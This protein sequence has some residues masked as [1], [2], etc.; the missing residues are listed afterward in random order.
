MKVASENFREWPDCRN[1]AIVNLAQAIK[2]TTTW[3][4]QI[5]PIMRL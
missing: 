3:Q 2:I 4:T 1:F 5:P